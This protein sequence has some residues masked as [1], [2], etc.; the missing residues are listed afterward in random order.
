ML[1]LRKNILKK[2][3]L[4]PSK[5]Y[6]TNKFKQWTNTQKKTFDTIGRDES[7]III[8]M[9]DENRNLNWV[10]RQKSRS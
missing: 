5:F 7:R 8:P 9:Y 1:Q 2:R 10:P 3:K 6:F 4:D